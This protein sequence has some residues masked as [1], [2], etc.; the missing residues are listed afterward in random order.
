MYRKKDFMPM[1]E[2]MRVAG[3]S[4]DRVK[5]WI[6]HCGLPTYRTP[7]D[8]IERQSW[9]RIPLAPFRLWLHARRDVELLAKFFGWTP[10]FLCVGVPTRVVSE[11]R[12]L[13][14]VPLH[15]VSDLFSGGLLMQKH[16]PVGM[17]I[18]WGLGKAVVAKTLRFV[19]GRYPAVRLVGLAETVEW[20]YT[21]A[22]NDP[23]DETLSGRFTVEDLVGAIT[24]EP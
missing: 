22:V 10:S 13:L 23:C 17:L 2:I 16:L 1:T 18:D 20:G 6:E 7:N 12:P 15:Y 14:S 4:R 5:Y 11:I 8:H 21:E 9:R 19:V 24:R 3:V